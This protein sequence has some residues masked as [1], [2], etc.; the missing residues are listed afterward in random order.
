MSNSSDNNHQKNDLNQETIAGRK[1]PCFVQIELKTALKAWNELE[2]SPVPPSTDEQQLLK[3]KEMIG[4]LSGK[5][6][7]F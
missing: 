7:Q 4:Q 2:D 5:L 3:I 6:E 1:R